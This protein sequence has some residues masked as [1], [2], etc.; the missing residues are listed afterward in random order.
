MDEQVGKSE[1][2]DGIVVLMSVEVVGISTEGL[3]ESVTVIEH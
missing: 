3:T 2:A 1:I